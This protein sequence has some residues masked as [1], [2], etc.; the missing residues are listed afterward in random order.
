MAGAGIAGAPP[1]KTGVQAF[2]LAAPAYMIPYIFC[3]AP[4]LTLL[5]YDALSGLH[6]AVTAI[7]GVLALGI[8][9][10]GWMRTWV[11][12]WQRVPLFVA[13]LFLI[14][15]G[16]ETDLAGFG[17]LAAIYVHQT[18]L[19]RRASVQV[20]PPSASGGSH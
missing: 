6:A 9:L 1:T 5:G 17:L 12:W 19:L 11:A 18:F 15:P 8:G 10:F 2:R 4:Q 13:A 3:F 7:L 20:A 14:V 16:W